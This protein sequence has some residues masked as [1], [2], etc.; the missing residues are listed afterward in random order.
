M[1][2]LEL[3]STN[4][5]ESSVVDPLSREMVESVPEFKNF[6]QFLKD[7]TRVPC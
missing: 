3:L 6:L 2:N 5:V 1:P 4:R 7:R